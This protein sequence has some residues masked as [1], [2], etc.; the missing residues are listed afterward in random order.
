MH[1]AGVPRH[2]GSVP[3]RRHRPASFSG[4]SSSFSE[5]T[6]VTAVLVEDNTEV[7]RGQPLFE[8]DRTVYA[9]KVAQLEAQLAA[10][11]QNVEIAKANIGTARGARATSTP[12][13]RPTARGNIYRA[14]RLANMNR[15]IRTSP[16]AC[17]P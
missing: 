15:R 17:M 7:K 5:P 10:V 9:A 4:L 1:K 12:S 8:F 2:D 11:K 14:T 3:H 16:S 13:G 6:L